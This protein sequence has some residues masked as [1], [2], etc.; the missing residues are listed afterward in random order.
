MLLFLLTL[1]DQDIQTGF[2]KEIGDCSQDSFT[3]LAA[4][5]KC[6]CNCIHIR[7]LRVIVSAWNMAELSVH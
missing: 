6:C 5:Q 3:V 1:T 7:N 4:D 2:I